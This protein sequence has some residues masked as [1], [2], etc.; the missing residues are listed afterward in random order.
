MGRTVYVVRKKKEYRNEWDRQ[1]FFAYKGDALK[2]VAKANLA[3]AIRSAP[4][5]RILRWGRKSSSGYM[6]AQEIVKR[7][8][9]GIYEMSEQ[10]VH[11]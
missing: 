7:I 3:D 9:E 10:H 8:S 4:K 6:E 5:L 11:V 2:E 1:E